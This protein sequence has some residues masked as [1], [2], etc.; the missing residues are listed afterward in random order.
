[1][2]K[3]AALQQGGY[4]PGRLLT[5]LI[6]ILQLKNDIALSKTLRVSNSLLRA[7]REQKL[8]I[9]GAILIQMHEVSKLSINELRSLMGDRRRTCRMPVILL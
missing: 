7:I 8:A 6:Y 2:T 3:I 5:H 1:M 9:A 4:D